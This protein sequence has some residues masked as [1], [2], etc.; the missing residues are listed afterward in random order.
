VLFGAALTLVTLFNA[1]NARY[2][3]NP[4]G[5][6]YLDLVGRLLAGDLGAF[7][8]GY[9]SPLYPLLLA[10]VAAVG[11]YTPRVLLIAAHALNALAVVGAVGLLWWWGR[12]DG[13]PRF[14]LAAFAALF[15]VSH[16]LPRIEA[17]TP[18]S[19]LIAM[20]IWLGYELLVHRGTRWVR[21]GLLAGAIFLVKTSSWPWLLVSIPLRLWGARD[22]GSRRD[23][24][25]SLPVTLAVMLLWVVPVSVKTGHPTLGSA[26]RLNYCWYIAVCD[27]Q[28][29]DT[30]L[31][32]HVAYH[33]AP[34]DSARTITWAEFDAERWTYAPWGDPTAWE[35]GLLT[36]NSSGPT[37]LGLADYW[38]RQAQFSFA[39]WLLP[40]LA[41]VLLPWALLEWRGERRRWWTGEGRPVLVVALLGLAGIFQF[42]LIHA[43]PR[44]IAPYGMLLALAVLSRGSEAPAGRVLQRAAALLG[45][46]LVAWY[47]WDK[48]REGMD[49][50]PRLEQ[51]VAKMDATNAELAAN[52][53]S[54]RRIVVLGAGIPVSSGAFLSGARIVAQLLPA[55]AALLDSLPP[56]ERHAVLGRL[57]GGRVQ[58]AWRSAADG[59]VSYVGVPPR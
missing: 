48:V 43:E 39:R 27:S 12:Q 23:V 24:L 28:T 31:G 5:V 13:G 34:I 2:V 19:L 46:V 14:T 45:V 42:I 37:A 50:G 44:L 3:L 38:G 10:P 11:G 47:G 4:D 6:S 20:T 1:W 57:F 32:R 33:T 56:D 15:L 8:Q 51:I 35:A 22:P 52:G 16:G 18:D 9:W 26:G 29:P 21:T 25:R 36:K 59:T 53:F 7:V 55:S 41:G 58:V 49:T 17:V 30:H 54:Q 40:M